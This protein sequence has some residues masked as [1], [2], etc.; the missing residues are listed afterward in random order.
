ML[1][2]R[3]NFVTM[4]L[5][6]A[7][8]SAAAVTGYKVYIAQDEETETIQAPASCETIT[9]RLEGYE[10]IKPLLYNNKSCESS[11]LQVL[12]MNIENA[13]NNHQQSGSIDQASVYLKVLSNREFISINDGKMYHPASLIKL[14]ILITYLQM[15][16]NHPGTLNKKLVFHLPK[17][18]VPP[19]TYNT[20]QIVPEKSYTINELLKYMVAYSDN[21]ATYLLNSNIDLNAFTKMFSDLGIK[22]PDVHD[23]DYQISA[24]DYSVFLNIIY[25]AGLLTIQNSEL[26]AKLLNECDFKEGIQ[27]GLPNDIKIIHKFGEWGTPTN[28]NIHQL[29]ESAIIYLDKTAYILT[30]M[31]QGKDVKKLPAVLGDISKTVYYHLKHNTAN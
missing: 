15:E 30:I 25:N 16:E 28:P 7:I 12:K 3:F 8:C 29:S 14:P 4:L 24:A 13:I 2:K 1:H 20:N 27:S 9:H 23:M 18:G 11:K 21:N 6:S 22:V 31:L 26:V 10:F 19:Q 17:G 5:T